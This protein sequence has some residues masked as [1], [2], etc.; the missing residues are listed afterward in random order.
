MIVRRPT[1]GEVMRRYVAFNAGLLLLLILFAATALRAQSAG[2]QAVQSSGATRPTAPASQVHATGC[3]RRGNDGGFYLKD[4]NG[5]TWVL[6][7]STVDLSQHIMHSVSIM[8]EI[9]K[10]QNQETEP[11]SGKPPLRLQVL[12]LTMLSPS[13]TR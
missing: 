1:C 9:M 4:H 11:E 6:S 8:G 5:Q 7:S 10:P 2:M 13:C 3:L 12:S